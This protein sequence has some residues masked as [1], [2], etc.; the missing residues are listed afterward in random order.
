MLWGAEP[1]AVDKEH[2]RA[3]DLSQWNARYNFDVSAA[4]AQQ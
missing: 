3:E 2:D 4:F 1:N